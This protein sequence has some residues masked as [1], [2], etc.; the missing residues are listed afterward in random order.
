VARG[1][2]QDQGG[3]EAQAAAGLAHG[4]GPLPERPA[5]SL[6][7]G[8]QQELA[9]QPGEQHLED[10][11]AASQGAHGSPLAAPGWAVG[12][13]G[14]PGAPGTTGAAYGAAGGSGAGASCS[15][16]AKGSGKSWPS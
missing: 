9:H 15:Q 13:A 4:G 12:E 7:A 11:P 1:P 3:A 5:S 2:L 8:E 6:L 14:A 16:R 10:Q